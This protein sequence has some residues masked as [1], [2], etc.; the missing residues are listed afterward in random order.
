MKLSAKRKSAIYSAIHEQIIDTR[1]RM[2]RGCGMP[3]TERLNTS[4]G[5]RIDTLIA[6]LVEPIYRNVLTVLGVEQ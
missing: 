4:E 1:L 3:A 5:A 6:Q 2:A